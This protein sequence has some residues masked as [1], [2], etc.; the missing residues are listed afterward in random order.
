L[1]NGSSYQPT[2]FNSLEWKELIKTENQKGPEIV[3]EEILQKKIW[4]NAEI[5]WVLKRMLFFY[6]KKDSLLQ[7]VPVERL[8]ANMSAV[9]RVLYIVID[10]QNPDLDNNLKSYMCAKLKDATWGINQTTRSYL[11]KI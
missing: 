6:G 10:Q 5:M 4:S 3:L 8:F 2:V 7:K 9:L 11:E 1:E